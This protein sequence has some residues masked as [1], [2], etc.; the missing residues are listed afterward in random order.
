MAPKQEEVSW[1]LWIQVMKDSAH[2][3]HNCQALSTIL[4]FKGVLRNTIF[5]VLTSL[6]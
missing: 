3:L 4:Y 6:P 1:A 5:F 2:V